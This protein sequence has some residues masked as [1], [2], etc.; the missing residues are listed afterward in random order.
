MN[1][2]RFVFS[3]FDFLWSNT[4]IQRWWKFYFCSW[5]SREKP[6][7]HDF[8]KNYESNLACDW[9]KSFSGM[10]IWENCTF[11][12]T[13]NDFSSST[14]EATLVSWNSYKIIQ[15][16]S[17]LQSTEFLQA[18]NHRRAFHS[19]K[20][21]IVQQVSCCTCIANLL[22]AGITWATTWTRVMPT[23]FTSLRMN[24]IE[25]FHGFTHA[26]ARMTAIVS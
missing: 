13:F 23:A 2:C 1:V 17:H 11:F 12:R 14:L 4:M 5:L 16:E 19:T 7:C 26:R 21:S 8:V 6:N 9:L 24:L 22:P 20:R 25:H 10:I 18:Q 3:P 15:S